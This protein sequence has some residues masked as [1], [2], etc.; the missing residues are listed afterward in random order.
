MKSINL[1]VI[2]QGAK[3]GIPYW[4]WTTSFTE[5]PALVTEKKD[6]PFHHGTTYNGHN[7]TRSPRPRLFNNPSAGDENFFYKQV[8]LAFEQ[9]DY[10]NFEV[11][12][13]SI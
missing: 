3:T 5:L 8:L 4:D 7:T 2:V 6:N 1:G 10:C 9:T 13:S 12:L 11:S